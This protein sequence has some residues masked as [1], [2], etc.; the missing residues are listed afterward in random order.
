[1]FLSWKWSETS[2][3]DSFCNLNKQTNHQPTLSF[4]F[5]QAGLKYIHICH[6]SCF[7]P[8][9]PQAHFMS[10]YAYF[11][12]GGKMFISMIL[13]EINVFFG[14][15]QKQSNVFKFSLSF[16]WG[17]HPLVE[18]C[19]NVCHMFWLLHSIGRCV[20]KILFLHK[21]HPELFFQC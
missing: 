15:V 8:P 11:P 5:L 9:P 2:Q 14:A 18:N 13:A 20:L 17:E 4:I 10:Q 16:Y 19:E 3:W 12:K 6:R 21:A 1:M 7:S